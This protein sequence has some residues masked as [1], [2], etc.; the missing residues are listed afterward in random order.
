MPAA[1]CVVVA[2]LS[3]AAVQSP[4]REL[5]ALLARNGVDR[6]VLGWCRG[7]FQR[8]RSGSFAVALGAVLGGTYNVIAPDAKMTEL[9]PFTGRPSVA[10]YSAA[11]ARKL[12]A[13]IR[14]SETIHSQL[15]PRWETTVICAFT[16]NTTSL[17]WQYSPADHAFVTVGQWIT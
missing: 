15:M 5:S 14:A 11:E 16:D 9:A 6:P 4:P 7:E 13:S 2:V 17:C 8:G 10:C 1:V 3:V 12:D